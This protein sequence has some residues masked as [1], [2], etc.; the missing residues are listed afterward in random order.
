MTT[1]NIRGK[2]N[3]ERYRFVHLILVDK[4]KEKEQMSIVFCS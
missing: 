4:I 3:E 2:G 1:G